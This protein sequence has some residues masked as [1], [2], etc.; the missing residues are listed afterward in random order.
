M[1]RSSS[2]G[3]ASVAVTS[4]S[5]DS[6]SGSAAAAEGSSFAPYTTPGTSIVTKE[7]QAIMHP[8]GSWHNWLIKVEREGLLPTVVMTTPHELNPV[9]S[10]ICAGA[11]NCL[12]AVGQSTTPQNGRSTSPNSTRSPPTSISHRI[13]PGTREEPGR[14]E[15]G[16]QRGGSGKENG[17]GQLQN[18]RRRSVHVPNEDKLGEY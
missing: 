4:N 17:M 10:F 12:N 5:N 14:R 11:S 1:T 13:A 3:S 9:F 18:R 7:N 16:T 8:N 15:K 2:G 6:C